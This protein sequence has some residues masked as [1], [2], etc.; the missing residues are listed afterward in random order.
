LNVTPFVPAQR[1]YSV[2]LSIFQWL[3]FAFGTI[4]NLLALAVLLRRR[5]STQMIMQLFIS[6]LVIADLG[7]MLGAAWIQAVLYV[8]QYW[9]FGLFSCKIF[10][11][12]LGL[13][14]GVSNWTLAVVAV[15]RL[16]KQSTFNCCIETNKT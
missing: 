14:V 7:L 8:D 9:K 10:F 15:D 6:S 5:K 2:P 13:T 16:V 12:V 4:N 1:L 11:F 3:I